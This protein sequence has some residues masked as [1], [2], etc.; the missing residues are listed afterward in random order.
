MLDG[1]EEGTVVVPV[2]CQLKTKV[3]SVTTPAKSRIQ[4]NVLLET[5]ISLKHAY[6]TELTFNKNVVS[7]CWR[8]F[9]FNT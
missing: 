6:D 8:V 1:E 2:T 7:S 4:E 9:D 3:P 5:G